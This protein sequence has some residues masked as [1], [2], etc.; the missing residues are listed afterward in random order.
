[1]EKEDT[2]PKRRVDYEKCGSGSLWILR[3]ALEHQILV[4]RLKYIVENVFIVVWSF[5]ANGE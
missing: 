2:L 3:D 1:M 5:E 4:S